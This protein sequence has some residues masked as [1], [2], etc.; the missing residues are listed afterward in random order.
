MTTENWLSL[1]DSVDPRWISLHSFIPDIYIALLQETYSEFQTCSQSSYGQREMSEEPWRRKTH[2]D[3][4]STRI[5]FCSVC[6]T[7]IAPTSR[8]KQL[9][10]NQTCSHLLPKP[11]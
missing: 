5:Q 7:Q 10:S 6:C 1:A 11:L 9:T 8:L 4:T 3:S 2:F